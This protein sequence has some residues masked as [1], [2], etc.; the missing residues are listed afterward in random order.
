M[1]NVNGPMTLHVRPWMAEVYQASSVLVYVPSHT[2]LANTLHGDLQI[3]A[4][5]TTNAASSTNQ[6]DAIWKKLNVSLSFDSHPCKSLHS[7]S[8][9][10]DD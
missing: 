3:I 1:D 5:E 2:F 9:V 6:F 4:A 10:V 8:I 7:P